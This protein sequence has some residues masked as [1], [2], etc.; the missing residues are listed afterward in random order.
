ML[1]CTTSRYVVDVSPRLTAQVRKSYLPVDVVWVLTAPHAGL[2][3]TKDI[4]DYYFQGLIYNLASPK[5]VKFQPI[6]WC[7]SD[8]RHSCKGPEL[9]PFLYLEELFILKT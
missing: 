2:I 8:I 4:R 7:N 5:R 1:G 6:G 3:F 9:S